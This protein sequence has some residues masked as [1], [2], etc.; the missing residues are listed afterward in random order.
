MG[1]C[2]LRETQLK[3]LQTLMAAA[4]RGTLFLLM[5]GTVTIGS[6][7][8]YRARAMLDAQAEH[9]IAKPLE[10]PGEVTREASGEAWREAPRSSAI[11][12]L[13]LEVHADPKP[14]AS[15]PAPETSPAPPAAAETTASSDVRDAALDVDL[16]DV[17]GAVAGKAGAARFT[18]IYVHR[19]AE[20][21]AA[22]VVPRE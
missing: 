14:A 12:S 17:T 15:E 11:A 13:A 6:V 21:P 20:P 16:A 1:D 10:A 8:V 7:A 5:V 3:R 4:R 19:G 22:Y 9:Y 18:T 2:V